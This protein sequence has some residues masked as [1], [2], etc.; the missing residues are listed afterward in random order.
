MT[1]ANRSHQNGSH[2]IWIN[3][4]CMCPSHYYCVCPSI[5]LTSFV[6]SKL[7]FSFFFLPYL[8]FGCCNLL[9]NIGFNVQQFRDT[10]LIVSVCQAHFNFI[11]IFFHSLDIFIKLNLQLYLFNTCSTATVL[12]FTSNVYFKRL[13]WFYFFHQDFFFYKKVRSTLNDRFCHVL[14]MDT[15]VL[16]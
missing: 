12:Q 4:F 1:N 16:I 10:Y 14:A 7:V 2:F 8:C 5:V 11:A 3:F 6:P 9:Q 15:H 13:C